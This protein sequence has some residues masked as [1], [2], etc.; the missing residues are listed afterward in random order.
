ML[1]LQQIDVK[2]TSNIK[3]WNSNSQP[4]DQE[5]LPTSTRPGLT[6]LW[7]SAPVLQIL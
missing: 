5:S 3:F 7:Y 6:A 4:T 1:C 2:V